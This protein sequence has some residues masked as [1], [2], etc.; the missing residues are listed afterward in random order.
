MACFMTRAL[1]R[2]PPTRPRSRIRIPR[3]LKSGRLEVMD[4]DHNQVHESTAAVPDRRAILGPGHSFGSIT[5]KIS[6]IV[7]TRR[8]SRGWYLGFGV[9]FLLVMLMLY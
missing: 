4:N 9:T 6:S 5:D 7:Q 2:E 8:T 1:G 3:S